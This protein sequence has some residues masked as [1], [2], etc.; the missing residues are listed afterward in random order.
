MTK[1]S[2]K[3]GEFRNVS[4]QKNKLRDII[5]KESWKEVAPVRPFFSPFS[6][7]SNVSAYVGLFGLKIARWISEAKYMSKIQLA[8]LLAVTVVGIIFFF[9]L[10]SMV[11]NYMINRNRNNRTRNKKD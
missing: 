8:L 10:L 9:L 7:F 2:V 11:E 1:I 6:R 3:N 5:V 4:Q